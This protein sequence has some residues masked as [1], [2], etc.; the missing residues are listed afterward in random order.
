MLNLFNLEI[1]LR[2]LGKLKFK[3]LKLR[4]DMIKFEISNYFY[5]GIILALFFEVIGKF[6]V[7]FVF[8]FLHE[9]AHI[10]IAKKFR[11]EVEKVIITP[12]GMIAVIKDINKLYLHE[13]L[14]LV[15]AGVFFNLIMVILL[16]IIYM[17]LNIECLILVRDI[18]ISII[19][20]NLLPI[21]PLDGS[22]FVLYWIGSK[23]GD[24]KGLKYVSRISKKF[25]YVIFILGILQMILVPYNITMLV[26]GIYFIKTN[27]DNLN[28]CTMEFYKNM[29]LNNNLDKSLD[30]ILKIKYFMIYEEVKI[31]ELMLYMSSEYYIIFNINNNINITQDEV[32]V[33]VEKYGINGVVSNVVDKIGGIKEI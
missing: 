28:M 25:S 13:K 23:I 14:T 9:M 19:I 22:K 29:C 30:K 33:Y 6:F 7:T 12:L 26:F 27:K 20:F 18:N 4:K 21:F 11:L 5:I 15:S 16:E 3:N 32:I 10:Y 8:I 1:K 17:L 24:L 31:K 2:K